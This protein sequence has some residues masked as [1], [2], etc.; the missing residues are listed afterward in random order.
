MYKAL[1]AMFVLPILL[2]TVVA[3]CEESLKP[4]T[5]ALQQNDPA[6]TLRLLAPLQTRCAQSATFNEVFGLANEL[7]GNKSAAEKAL[8]IAVELDGTSP[9]LLTELGA[10]LLRN[11]KP[12][13]AGRALDRSL[14]IDPGNT[15]TLKY[16][17]GAAVGSRNWQHAAELFQRLNVGGDGRMLQQEP[18]LLLWF[19]ETLIETRQ[20]D[21][22]DAV[23]SAQPSSLPPGLLFSLGTVFAQHGMYERAIEYLKQVPPGAADDALYFNLGLAYSHLQKF[24]EARRCYFEAIDR[25]PGHADAYLH[26][27]LD[28]LASG[29]ARMGIPWIYRARSFAPSRA[30]IA[31]ALV[32]QLITLEYFNSAKEVLAPALASAPHDALLLVADGDLKRAQGNSAAAIV[33]DRQALAEKPGLTPA[34]VGLAHADMTAGKESE[35]KSVLTAA[36]AHNPQDPIVSGELGLL[37]AHQGDW[38]AAFDHLGRAWVQDH[39]NPE[40]ALQLA[41]AYRQKGHPQ[42]ALKLLDSISPEM[43]DSSAFHFERAQLYTALHRSAEA[44]AERDTLTNLQAHSQDALHFENPRTYVH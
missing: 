11:G 44:Q 10:T 24:E 29:Q 38:D 1:L 42:D 7:S 31:Y 15:V 16:A 26:V 9:R 5:L 43:Q 13:E 17:V 18:V 35:A 8:R 27:G 40:I 23:L 39:S 19:V 21:R 2:F 4:A 25:H 32:E 12:A 6:Q 3:G 37:E 20:S 41:R 28:Y 30:D 34:L 33:S 36:L 22:I 14:K